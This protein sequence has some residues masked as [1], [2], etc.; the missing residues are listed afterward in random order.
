MKTLWII[1]GICLICTLLA[2][3]LAFYI[4]VKNALVIFA[5][6]YIFS[7]LAGVILTIINRLEKRTSLVI[8]RRAGACFIFAILTGVLYLNADSWI[9]G[10]AN[11]QNAAGGGA[12]TGMVALF[13]TA[14]SWPLSFVV[15]T[16]VDLSS[17][18]GIHNWALS[19][20]KEITHPNY[21]P[22]G[23]D[24]RGNPIN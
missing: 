15:L 9:C 2:G 22:C 1:H 3:V 7:L 4:S 6:Y 14:F 17:R 5:L 10:E 23:V 16:L 12:A 8:L 20:N 13:I 24:M 21:D 19:M 18:F 11:A